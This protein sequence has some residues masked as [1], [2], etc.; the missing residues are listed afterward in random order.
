MKERYREIFSLKKPLKER[1]CKLIFDKIFSLVI[2]ILASPLFLL[3]FIAYFAEDIIDPQ[4]R[5][6]IFMPYTASNCGKKFRKCKFR[7]AKGTLFKQKAVIK[8]DYRE[9]PS[10]YVKKNLTPI[11]KFLKDYY[12]DELPQIFNILKGDMSFVGPRPLAW[13]HYLRDAKQGNV[14]R[15]VLKAGL[16]SYSHTRKGTPDFARPE[17]DYDYIEEYMKLSALSLLWVDIKIIARGIK[18]ILEGKGL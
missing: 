9:Y 8:G 18:M 1:P 14:A 10:E 6:P 17:L 4:N 16:F 13:H 3:I 2:I 11:G 15:K 5:G 7:V 12:L